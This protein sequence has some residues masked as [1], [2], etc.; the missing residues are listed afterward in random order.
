M[1]HAELK[2]LFPL[3]LIL[4][5]ILLYSQFFYFI[6]MAI[7]IINSIV[8]CPTLPNID[9]KWIR[10]GFIRV[11][12]DNCLA[13]YILYTYFGI[14]ISDLSYANHMMVRG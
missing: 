1:I 5:E 9:S 11:Y 8:I 7:W 12:T 10:Q 13:I 4:N 14:R 3:P 2:I 6:W